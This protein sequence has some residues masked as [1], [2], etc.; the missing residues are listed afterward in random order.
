[1]KLLVVDDDIPT[2]QAVRDLVQSWDLPIQMIFTAYNVV[3]AK[4]ILE[5]EEVDIVICDIEMPK[6]S[7]MQLLEWVR[8]KRMNQEFIFLTCHADFDYAAQA[9]EYRADAYITKP[10]N[11]NALKNAMTKLV[12]KISYQQELRRNS[13]YGQLWLDREER[14]KSALW[15]DILFADTA[16]LWKTTMWVC[17]ARRVCSSLWWVSCL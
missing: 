14:I 11:P 10:L 13:E 5:R 2:T 16:A 1:M 7:G 8:G 12:E 6:Y 4:G 3:E 17:P 15:R 9:L